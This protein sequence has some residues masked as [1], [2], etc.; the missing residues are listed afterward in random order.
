MLNFINRN[1]GF[2]LLMNTLRNI[3]LLTMHVINNSEKRT[4]AY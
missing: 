1:Y 2:I 4:D 3:G